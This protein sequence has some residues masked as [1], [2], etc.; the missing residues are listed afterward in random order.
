MKHALLTLAF[1]LSPALAFAGTNGDAPA[2]VKLSAK[3]QVEVTRIQAYL[4]NLKNISA[5]FMQVTDQGGMMTGKIAIQRPGKMRVTYDA[6]SKDFIVADGG[7][8][9]IW[10]DEL[11][12]QTNVDEGSSLAEFI[13]RDPIH[14]SGDVTLTKLEHFPAKIEMTLVQT[15]DPASGSLTL[16]FEDKPLK[17]RQWR[18]IDPQGHTTGVNLQNMREDVSFPASTFTFT[19]PSFGKGGGASK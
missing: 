6:P 2:P 18:V 11:K 8:V 7:T 12:S 14:L 10:D 3:D 5:D 13:L 9:H 19:P 4:N 17:L 15:D 16:I 1:I